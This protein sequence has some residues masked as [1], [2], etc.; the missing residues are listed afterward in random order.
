MKLKSL[1]ILIG[2]LSM[3][4]VRAQDKDSLQAE[5]DRWEAMLRNGEFKNIGIVVGVHQF[6]QTFFELGIGRSKGKE[7]GCFYGQGF[8]AIALSA[9]YNPFKEVGGLLL[10]GWSNG[11]SIVPM[12]IGINLHAYTDFNQVN[13]GFR[14][15]IGFGLM[16]FSLT[17]GYN[18]EVINNDVKGINR[19]N[20]SLRYYIRMIELI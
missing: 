19:H 5:N 8:S 3:M 4:T 18:I 13:Y 17:Y 11:A 10:T 2:L 16:P 14:P 12:S 15:M 1:F 20:F 9:E 6:K 7:S